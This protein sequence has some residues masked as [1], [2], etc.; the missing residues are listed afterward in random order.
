M[1]TQNLPREGSMSPSVRSS[2][3]R[4]EP[5]PER[6]KYVSDVF[7]RFFVNAEPAKNLQLV[8][9]DGVAE[10]IPEE[11]YAV[12]REVFQHLKDGQAISLIPDDTLLTT[13][14]AAEILNVSRPYLYRLLDA[15]EIPFVRVGTHRKLRLADVVALR[16]RRRDES[17]NAL[18]A[19]ATI[20]QE[21]DDYGDDYGVTTRE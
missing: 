3:R 6:A 19:I 10:D 4:L 14:Q 9:P 20:N 17:R 11:I 1:A 16:E 5:S 8:G 18:N 15:D 2:V 13:Q 7:R 21:C 12:L